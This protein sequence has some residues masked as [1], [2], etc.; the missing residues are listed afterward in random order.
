V[1]ARLAG[2]I[3]DLCRSQELTLFMFFAGTFALHLHRLTGQDEVVIGSPIS[4]RLRPETHGVIGLF[5]N[6]LPLHYRFDDRVAVGQFLQTVKK[7]LLRDM[8]NAD[9]Q[10]EDIL[11]S[12]AVRRTVDNRSVFNVMVAT[13]EDGVETLKLGGATARSIDVH[14]GTSKFDLLLE[15]RASG[16]EL[17]LVFEYAHERLRASTVEAL[18]QGFVALLRRI[19]AAPEATLA[20]LGALEDGKPWRTAGPTARGGNGARAVPEDDAP[21]KRGPSGAL[22]HELVRA[23]ANVLKI[24]PEGIGVHDSFFMLGGDSHAVMVVA[25]TVREWGYSVKLRELFANDTIA[26]LRALLDSR[27]V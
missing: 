27:R 11:R 2:S 9:A 8:A 26:K 3:R 14:N 18:G 23:W 15:V 1:D 24:A 19:V 16:G 6:T 7:D 10:L 20:G 22:E 13:I 12:L 17:R 25:K 21:P 5:L 4:E